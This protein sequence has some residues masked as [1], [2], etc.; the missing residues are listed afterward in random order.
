[1]EG[2]PS[3]LGKHGRVD[4]FIHDN[5]DVEKLSSNLPLGLGKHVRLDESVEDNTDV[6]CVTSNLRLSI[7]KENTKAHALWAEVVS[8]INIVSIQ[9]TCIIKRCS[10]LSELEKNMLDDK[11]NNIINNYHR[12]CNILNQRSLDDK[13]HNLLSHQIV[14]Y[15]YKKNLVFTNCFGIP[16][17]NIH[18]NKLLDEWVS[19]KRNQNTFVC[20]RLDYFDLFKVSH[21][22]SVYCKDSCRKWV[23][24]CTNC[25][26]SLDLYCLETIWLAVITALNDILPD[27]HQFAD[28]VIRSLL[29]MSASSTCNSILALSGYNSFDKK[30]TIR[31]SG[32]YT[33]PR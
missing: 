8:L 16:L 15:V 3:G 25:K 12:I 10:N 26:K 29:N 17:R 32:I 9:N 27:N 24:K 2:Q 28:N 30:T 13:G 18:R 4:E 7:P 20:S 31:C 5:S 21:V 11:Q 19:R 22:D 1:M 33:H 14:K 23:T 6:E